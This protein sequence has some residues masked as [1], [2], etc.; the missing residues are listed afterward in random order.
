MTEKEIITK[1]KQAVLDLMIQKAIPKIRAFEVADRAGISRSTLYRY[2]SSVD[3]IVKEMQHEFFESLREINKYSISDKFDKKQ[4]E[5]LLESNKLLFEFMNENR[6]FY[7]A[8]TG[9][10]G[11]GQFR[12]KERMLVREYYGGKMAYE[13]LTNEFTEATLVFAIAGHEALIDY[14]IR[15]RP[16][17][18]PAVVASLAQK[19][20][21]G[22]FLL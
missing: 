6:D 12:H 4:P 2:Y 22:M 14:W 9:P 20:M 15:Q 18:P 3:E 11:D 8:I 17:I 1:V 7:L 21:Y 16:D 10:H 19:L 5:K 13:G